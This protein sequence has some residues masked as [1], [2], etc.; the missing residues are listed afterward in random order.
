MVEAMRRVG[1]G[2]I[3]G[4]AALPR[5]PGIQVEPPEGSLYL[6]PRLGRD[7]TEVAREL[8]HRHHVAMVPGEVFG[9]SRALRLSLTAPRPV[10]E[11]AAARLRSVLE[12]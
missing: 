8:L 4:T 5:C 12:R 9:E 7:G 11:E 10:L 3:S 6:F 2:E 1:D